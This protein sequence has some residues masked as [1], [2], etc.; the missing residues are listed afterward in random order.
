MNDF[1]QCA[2]FLFLLFC[3][4]VYLLH[5]I[6]A[7]LCVNDVNTSNSTHLSVCFSLFLL[8]FICI[9]I[10]V[11]VSSCFRRKKSPL[12]FAM[13]YEISLH[14]EWEIRSHNKYFIILVYILF[15]TAP[16]GCK[17]KPM[18]YIP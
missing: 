7:C 12:A 18:E 16:F 17:F 4:F 11:R 6:I 2:Y 5:E 15:K 10:L 3:I 8:Y 14:C 9:F 13:I 1:S